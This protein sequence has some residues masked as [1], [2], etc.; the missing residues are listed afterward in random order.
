M[1]RPRAATRRDVLVA[2]LGGAL[3]AM[4]GGCAEKRPDAT[5]EG[6]VK[7]LIEHLRRLDG[8]AKQA[9]LAFGLLS[10]QTRHNLTERAERYSQAS[11]KHIEPEMMIAPASFIERFHARFLESEVRGNHAL[12]RAKGLLEDE[13][14][15]IPCVYEEGGWR[16]H[17][18]LPPLP[19]V[20]IRPRESDS[21]RP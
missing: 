14:A 1:T 11:G 6:A 10:A 21:G 15:Q 13:S 17:M 3:L 19:A 8:S 18:E 7:E 20:V 16:V 4:S 9:K 5:P 2:A 12:V